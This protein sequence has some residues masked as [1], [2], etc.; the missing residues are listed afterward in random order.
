MKIIITENRLNK[1]VLKWLD[2][3]YGNLISVIKNK[4]VFYVDEN[5]LPLFFYYSNEKTRNLYIN[6]EKIWQLLKTIFSMD[7][8]QI[9]DILK[10]WLE[11]TYNLKGN[12]IPRRGADF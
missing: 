4:K 10:I 8:L 7:Y 1:V 5:G 12:V 11:E 2:N 3:E 9:H 6:Y